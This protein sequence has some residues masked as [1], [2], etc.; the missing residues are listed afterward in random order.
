MSME[1]M[2]RL[3]K[4]RGVKDPLVLAAMR[5]VPRHRFVPDTVRDRAYGD[6]PLAIGHGQTISQPY[7]VAMMT[8]ALELDPGER[9]LEIGTGSGY[10]TAILAEMDMDVYTIEFVPELQARAEAT[11]TTLGYEDV[12]YRTG[13]GWQGWLEHAPYDGI[14]VTAAPPQIPDPLVEQIADGGRMVIPVGPEGRY[15]TLWKIIREGDDIRK[16]S[17]GGVAFVPLVH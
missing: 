9:V 11:L 7:I 8:E 14:I 4:A 13:D 6:Y 12:H 1:S 15:Q 10:Q 16:I 2:L 5:N 17:M 3:I